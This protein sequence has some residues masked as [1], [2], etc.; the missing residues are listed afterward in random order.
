MIRFELLNAVVVRFNLSYL[1]FLSFSFLICKTR[2][3]LPTPSVF[4]IRNIYDDLHNALIV[5]LIQNKR[6]GL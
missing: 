4:L 5:C 6:Q 1:D 2:L 3:M